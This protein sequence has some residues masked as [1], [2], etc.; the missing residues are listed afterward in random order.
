LS[1]IGLDFLN[2]LWY[3]TNMINKSQ[4]VRVLSK[5]FL[6]LAGILVFLFN[7]ESICLITDFRFLKGK[8]LEVALAKGYWQEPLRQEIEQGTIR[9]PEI[10]L[11]APLIKSQTTEI[12]EIDKLLKQGAVLYP[13]TEGSKA[14][15]PLIILG[16]SAPL[17]WPK[18]GNYDWIFSNLNSL[19][20]G[21][22][23]TLLL[24]GEQTFYKVIGKQIIK[25]G[26]EPPSFN[27]REGEADLIL[28]SCWPPGR[29][30]QRIV[31]S[32]TLR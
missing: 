1:S 22:K 27:E 26:A 31:V 6:I 7:F 9:I 19:E 23:F 2:N 14:K 16:H 28:I 17:N 8:V 4:D 21:V 15:D 10:G 12:K 3:D 11:I 32:A 20:K 29:N 24:N 30:S 25:K 18:V 13:L 5:Y